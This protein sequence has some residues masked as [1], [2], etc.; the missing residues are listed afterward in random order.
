VNMH[1]NDQYGLRKSL[2]GKGNAGLI[3]TEGGDILSHREARETFCP[4]INLLDGRVARPEK[5]RWQSED[6]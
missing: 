5:I 2:N 6:E 4:G 1:V 3:S